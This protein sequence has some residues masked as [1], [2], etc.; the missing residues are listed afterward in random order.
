VAGQIILMGMHFLRTVSPTIWRELP[1]RLQQGQLPEAT[2]TRL[3][4]TERGLELLIIEGKELRQCLW[5]FPEIPPAARDAAGKMLPTS[6]Q[7]PLVVQ[8][9]FAP[10]AN[11]W[12]NTQ[13]HIANRLAS[14]Q[15][16]PLAWI[17]HVL[18]SLKTNLGDGWVYINQLPTDFFWWARGLGL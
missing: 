5:V 16:I 15:P 1:A 3:K 13:Q 6:A 11:G 10:F 2:T 9:L 14:G 7:G 8:G 18:W 17:N 12:L 4:Q